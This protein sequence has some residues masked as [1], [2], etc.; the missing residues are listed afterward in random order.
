M[1]DI[2]LVF[3]GNVYIV[4]LGNNNGSVQ[5]GIRP[6]VVIGNNMN[7]IHSTTTQIIPLTTS[8]K[9]KLPIHVNLNKAQY[10]FLNQDSVAITEQ[11]TTVDKGQIRQFI[12]VLT[13]RDVN[14]IIRCL[15]IQVGKD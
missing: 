10:P 12:G 1:D 8:D 11:I 6:C 4:D 7:N 14:K 3:R 15:N 5:S 9:Q 2:R 13:E